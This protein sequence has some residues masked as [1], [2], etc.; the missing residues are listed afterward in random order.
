MLGLC[1]FKNKSSLRLRARPIMELIFIPFILTS[2]LG[3]LDTDHRV[4]VLVEFLGFPGEL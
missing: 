4:K 2:T 1:S 3:S